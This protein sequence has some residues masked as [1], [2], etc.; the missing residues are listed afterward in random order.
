MSNNKSGFNPEKIT[1]GIEVEVVAA[2]FAKGPFP[3]E[4]VNC[5]TSFPSFISSHSR[6]IKKYRKTRIRGEKILYDVAERL[7][8]G[9]E[10][11]LMYNPH[12]EEKPSYEKWIVTSDNSIFYDREKIER[13]I[14]GGVEIVSPK[15]HL[16]ST[17]DW[18]EQISNVFSILKDNY[19]LEFPPST[20]LHVHVGCGDEFRQHAGTR[21][22][23]D[24]HMWVLFCTALVRAA[25]AIYGETIQKM[26]S[27]KVLGLEDLSQLVGEQFVGYYGSRFLYEVL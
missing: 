11:E 25:A 13:L 3:R 10:V 18:K 9:V 21:H 19:R 8:D 20:G 5:E 14:H 23:E 16:V 4:G 24:I 2:G 15:F 7:K 12:P 22:V 1:F 17:Q 26:A 27:R 6:I